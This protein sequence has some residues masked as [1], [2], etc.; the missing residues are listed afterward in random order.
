[1]ARA[2]R[3]VLALALLLGCRANQ[4]STTPPSPYASGP[5]RAGAP[6]GVGPPSPVEMYPRGATRQIQ[7]ALLFLAGSS[8]QRLVRYE[9]VDGV[10]ILEGDIVLGPVDTLLLRYGIPWAPATNVKSAVATA[11]RSHLWPRAEIPYEIDPSCDSDTVAA[12]GRAIAEV[13]RTELK[14]RPRLASDPDYARFT[15]KGSGC[16]SY[17]GRKGGPQIITVQFC[18]EGSIAHE[19]LHA[20]GFYHEQSRGDRDS[21]ITI[22]W[23]EIDPDYTF[24]FEKR[25]GNGQDIGY[26]DYASVMQYG[27]RAFSR[28]GKP[29]I[30]TRIPNTPIGQREGLSAG[31]KAAITYLYGAGGNIPT[32]PP[33]FP[34]PVPTAIPTNFL[35][36][37]TP[38]TPPPPQPGGCAAGQVRD[39]LLRTCASP[40]PG[41]APPV[42][43]VCMPAGQSSAPPSAPGAC[44]SGQLP[45]L[46]TTRCAAACSSGGPRLNGQCWP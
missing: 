36:V 32:T 27:A 33:G 45:D 38:Q 34:F 23:D 13:N 1:M 28:T 12:I 40:C 35:P 31:D 43:G 30:V 10:A 24:A 14:V 18:G 25:D 21:Y 5:L 37:P 17:L 8:N 42:A 41:G 6:Q 16:S 15:A 44:P 26:Y 19:I 3:S 20:A 29:T 22:M 39:A 46:L 2:S 7:S 4:A 11:N 9:V